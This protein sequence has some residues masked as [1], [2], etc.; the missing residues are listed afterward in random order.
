MDE[1]AVKIEGLGTAAAELL[2]LVVNNEDQLLRETGILVTEGATPTLIN[3]VMAN[4]RNGVVEV[5]AYRDNTDHS[6]PCSRAHSNWMRIPS[7]R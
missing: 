3:N 1:G 2:P 6:I 4:L 7:R 5:A